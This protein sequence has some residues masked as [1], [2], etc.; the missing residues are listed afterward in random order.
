MRHSESAPEVLQRPNKNSPTTVGLAVFSRLDSRRLPGKAL[1]S[2]GGRPLLGHVIDRVR[3]AVELDT[4]I[5][6]TSDRPTDDPIAEFAEKAGARVFRGSAA[7][8]L[9]RAV[10]CARAFGLD[11]LVRTCG[12]SPFIDPALIDTMVRLHREKGADITTNVWPRTFPAGLS[13]EV[14]STT[15]LETAAA[16]TADPRHREHVTLYFYENAKNFYIHNECSG[17]I[18]YEGTPLTVDTPQDLVQANWIATTLA[19]SGKE[20]T[21]REVVGMARQWR[22]MCTNAAIHTI[23]DKPAAMGGSPAV[24]S[25]LPPYP[26]M[27]EAEEKAVVDVVRSGCLSGFFGSPGP[28]FLG[29]PKVRA[30]ERAWCER[31]GASHAVSVN[32]ATSGL[33][34][35]IGAVGAGP[36]DEIIVPPWTMSA[37]A[38]APLFYGA[39]PVFADIEDRTFGLDPKMVEAEI[40][41]KTRAIV[42]VNLFGHPARLGELRAIADRRGIHL[43][44][45]NAQAPLGMENGRPCGTIG[46]IGVFSLNFHKHIHTGEGGVCVTDDDELAKRLQLIRNHGENAAEGLGVADLTNHIGLNLRMGELSAAV[47]LE[48]LARI[49]DHVGRRERLAITLSEGTCDLAGWNVPAVRDGCRHNYYVWM[50]RYDS[51]TV[52]LSRAAFSKALA[53]EGFP[54]AVGYVPPLYRLPVFR[55]RR[56]IGRDGF[57][58][59]LTNRTYDDGLCPVAERLHEHEA[60][61]FEPC[62]YAVDNDTANRLVEA[63]RKV[64]VYREDLAFLEMETA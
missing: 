55:Q 41:P 19:R 17:A 3:R 16:M 54:H 31:Y 57:P 45:D 12:D 8:V 52:G 27:G 15:A 38:I 47:G 33:L 50:V 20:A 46:H 42:A 11:H 43:I 25:E 22:R 53:M 40:T 26:S 59:N 44:E 30:F 9:G 13:V 23:T 21:M 58:F 28:E 29:G 51:P 4:I 6:A 64:H 60:L 14:V 1:R 63:I 39:I 61:L 32:S 49:D 7:D 56:A 48:Q 37:T 5:V 36:G 24:L 18:G 35:A 62:A 10:A 34:A 2:F